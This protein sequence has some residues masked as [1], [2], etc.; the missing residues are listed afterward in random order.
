MKRLKM[1]VLGIRAVLGKNEEKDT[2]VYDTHI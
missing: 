2:C 1:A